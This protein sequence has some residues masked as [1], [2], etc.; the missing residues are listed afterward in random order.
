MY[1][2]SNLYA[3][4]IYAEH[5]M[6]FW[7]LDDKADYISLITDSQRDVSDSDYWND[8]EGGS[9]ITYTTKGSPPFPESPEIT[10]AGDITQNE[11]GQVVCISKD[12]ANFTSLNKKLSTFSI[13]AFF[14]SL[15]VYV[16]SFEIGYEY[17]DTVSSS[18]IQRLKTYFSSVKD[19]WIFISETFDTPE[20]NT[21]FRIV[22][23]INYIGQGNS[24]NDYKFLINGISAGQ[25]SE[26]FNAS[27]LGVIAEFI[28]NNI[29]IEPTQGI[30]A[31]AYGRQ[32]KKGY[33]LV[34]SNSL[35]A[36]NTGIP[37]VYGASGLTKLL[38]NVN[39]DQTPKPS[40]I[41]PGQG[42][43][44]ADGQYKEYTLEAWLRIN[45]DSIT[46]KRIIGPLGS[47]NGLYV[48]GPYLILKIGENYGS[49]YVG[50][51]TR[52]MLVHIRIGEDNASLL[53][54][55]EEVISL[56]YLTS[57]LS[58][59]VSLDSDK[60]NQDWIGFYAYEDVSPIEIDCVALYT[61]K[62]PIVLAK[63]RFVYGQGV[64]FP[65]GIN[66]A[67]SGSSI[68]I[69][70]PFA[71]Y[72]NNY[73]YPSLGNWSQATVDNLKT[74]SNL[75]STPDYKL[76]EIV[77]DGQVYD[78][79]NLIPNFYNQDEEGISF[80][81]GNIEGSYLYFDSLNFLKEKVKSFYGSFKFSSLSTTK[82][83]L[84]KAESKTSPNY[85]EISC[86][87]PTIVYTLNYNGTEQNLVTLS[88]LSIDKIFSVGVDIDTI[89][90]YF[91][92]NVASFFGNSSS[93]NFYIAGSSNP[94]E[95]FSGEIYKTGFCTY[96]NHNE[97]ISFFNEKG[98]VR[99][100]D[101]VFVE[102]LNIPDV[103]YN[104]TDEYF[105]NSL[106]EWDS[107]IDSG[108]PILATANT[109]QSHTASYTLSPSINFGS[110]SLD[111]D[112]QGYWED[113]LPLTYFAKFIKDN[114]SK[115]YYDLDFIQ[116][117]INYPAPSVFVEE[118]QFGSWTYGEL[119]DVYNIPIQRDYS[120]L[121]N[122]LFTGYLDYTDLRDRVYRNYKYDTSQSLVKSYITFQ[123]IKNGAN[124]SS[125][126]FIN[127]EK[128]SNDS[129]VI[130]GEGWRNTKYEVVDNMVIYTPKD[131]SNLDLAIVTHLEFNV[132]GIL[133]NKIAIRNLEYSS[134]A[135]NNT[136]P[137]PIGTR[138]GHSLFPYKKS[139]LYYDYKTENPFTIY[140]GTSPYL[141]LTRYSGI[142]IKGVMDPTINR[143]LSV[144]V[145]KEKSDNFKI[146]ALQMAVRYD[147][148]A[149]PYGSIEVFEIKA[150]DRHIKFYLSAIH[151]E[152]HRAKI[153]AIDA[154]TGRLENGIKFYLNGKIVKDP[155]LTVKEWAFLGISFPRVL[156][157]KNR[158]GLINFNG[159]LMFNTISYYES[160][161]LQET[162]EI[163]FRRWF[164]VKYIL[165]ENID[166]Q[167]WM[168]DDGLW[169]G[170]LTLS[171]TNYYG[172]DPSTIYKS[173]T[174][175]N[176]III[177]SQAS[178]VIDNARS[179]TEHE[180]RIY[181][182]INS[183]L[184]TTTAI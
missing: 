109:L 2:P 11:F 7:A 49:H 171:K 27:S 138:F 111:I 136:S 96:R 18:T 14:K 110:Y 122:Q 45:S 63:K 16:Y 83:V 143:G 148:D 183:K 168:D 37:L 51:W 82:Q 132:K 180:Y 108:L 174:G 182:G 167:Y 42:F 47:D 80:S 102:Y 38:P 26:E 135:F 88:Q 58:F 141:Y 55:G 100:S 121:D 123:Y 30:E 23:K 115:P 114:K 172:V 99:Q 169:D 157:F 74:D 67:Y 158:V 104:S 142:E 105:G 54:N 40:L 35:M 24:T 106:S 156:D 66:Q 6:A 10:I 161:N 73:S 13:G 92:G 12:I 164:G 75:L 77:L 154:N 79:E 71:K 170:V 159:P 21:T 68:Y 52:P 4:K 87:G 86:T 25:W 130:P 57:L 178:L 133:K 162:E 126:N 184:I 173:Y 32:D 41:I 128:P 179:N 70:Y 78:V 165:P 145:N 60:K 153:Y 69:D 93:L 65:E 85:F 50:E 97:I 48:E 119:S 28:P 134:Q 140:K 94:E 44:G 39:E 34:S 36:K 61:Y 147:K 127:T 29:S 163:E 72:A 120:S 176:K 149:F 22:I 59:P 103:E 160:T 152:G 177:D 31:N 129:F 43:L 144:S 64:E 19:K 3:E 15:S 155:V 151:P 113:Y 150:R 46:K 175:T 33:Y 117:N 62:V 181:S 112:I 53:I 9:A 91:G 90:H 8:T 5:P 17:Y 84:F 98:I 125:E 166:W 139:G 101:E 116:F 56:K 89:S 131:V 146:M 81:F 20:E 1:N 137:N 118:E 124:L 95:T 76:P 107:V